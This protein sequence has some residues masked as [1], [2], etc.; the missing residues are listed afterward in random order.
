M[1][2]RIKEMLGNDAG[3]GMIE[4]VAY[5]LMAGGCGM[6]FRLIGDFLGVMIDI[7]SSL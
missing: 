2:I 4:P 3:A 5:A 7:L 6:A 1:E